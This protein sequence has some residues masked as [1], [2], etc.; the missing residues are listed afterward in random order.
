MKTKHVHLPLN[1]PTKT[2]AVIIW[3]AFALSAFGTTDEAIHKQFTV[4]SGGK[5]I[6]DVAVGS[7][8]VNT[9]ATSEV[10]VDVK[11]KVGR[12][13][14]A[15]E[16]KYLKDYPVQLTQDGETVTIQC[17]SEKSQGS[18]NIWNHRVNEAEYTI[19]VPAQFNAKL[20]TAGG[21][22]EVNDLTGDIKAHTSGGGLHFARIH[23]PL[24][25]DTSG[26][27]IH[28]ADCDGEVKINTSGGGIDVFGGGG[29]LD[30]S[31]SGGP[32]KVSNFGGPANVETSGG[33]ITLENIAGKILGETSGG[34][35]HATLV[36]PLP[37]SVKLSTSG[38][39]IT[40]Q[41]PA[42]AAFDLDA[43]TSAGSVS[44]DLPVTVSGKI[45]HDHLRGPVNGG[46]NSV[47]LRTSGGGIHIVKGESVA[48]AEAEK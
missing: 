40:V 42:N 4:K 18:F 3:A 14:K 24:N 22:I 2:A 27:P 34:A 46:G 21:P 30:G 32:V 45:H 37:G 7:I 11:R 19:T 1:L 41:V 39:A 9:N 12:K 48:K 15:D 16:Q 44:S 33:G 8:T 17:R 35:I 26:G 43:A 10:V 23:G 36:S 20:H 47:F 38:G 25:G 29:A 5:I 31:T 28:V 6:V 13:T